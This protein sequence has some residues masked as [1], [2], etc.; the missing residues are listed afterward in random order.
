MSEKPHVALRRVSQ[1]MCLFGV[2]ADI[3]NWPGVR[4]GVQ[5]L[6]AFFPPPLASLTP[7]TCEV[8]NRSIVKHEA[9]SL[10]LLLI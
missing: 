4:A 1:W 10:V 3:E 7:L 8:L 9:E 2:S 5:D 6:A